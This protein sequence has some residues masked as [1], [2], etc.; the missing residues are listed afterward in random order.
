MDNESKINNYLADTS[1]LYQDW[2]TGF[3]PSEDDN[4]YTTPVGIQI[5]PSDQIKKLFYQWFNKNKKLLR[6]KLC[7]KWEYCHKKADFS[8]NQ[9][10]YIAYLADT[11]T[12]ILNIAVNTI[13]TATILH[14]EKYLDHLCECE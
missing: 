8:K 1:K 9:T 5:P 3:N 4:Q 14:V 12:I 13:A 2:Y 10:Q 11:L 7:D 6:E